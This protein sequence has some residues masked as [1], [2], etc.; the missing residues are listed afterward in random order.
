M[1]MIANIFNLMCELR[2]GGR[3]GELI[4]DDPTPCGRRRGDQWRQR[5]RRGRCDG[6]CIWRRVFQSPFVGNGEADDLLVE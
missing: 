1:S 5:V 3:Q 2:T 4:H 6:Y